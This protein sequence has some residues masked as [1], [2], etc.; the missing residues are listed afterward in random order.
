MNK[1]IGNITIKIKGSLSQNLGLLFIRKNKK[2]K[3]KKANN[4]AL[5]IKK[6]KH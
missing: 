1:D 3:L 2:K 6:F 4:Y 5:A